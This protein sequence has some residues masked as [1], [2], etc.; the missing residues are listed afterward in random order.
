MSVSLC[1]QDE[2]ETNKESTHTYSS[3]KQNPE[4]KAGTALSNQQNI[5]AGPAYDDD[6]KL[7]SKKKPVPSVPP[8]PTAIKS[9]SVK[10]RST[11]PCVNTGG[12]CNSLVTVGI[13][14]DD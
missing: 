4:S 8:T 13:D 11:C 9:N 7:Q 6:N 3:A 12:G 5:D 2:Q 10:C 14:G 1:H